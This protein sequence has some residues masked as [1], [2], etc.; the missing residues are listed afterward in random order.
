M[1]TEVSKDLFRICSQSKM[2]DSRHDIHIQSPHCQLLV[3]YNGNM[4]YKLI[5]VYGQTSPQFS[6]ILKR[7]IIRLNLYSK[8]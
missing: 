8:F 3:L 5:S 6:K 7:I 1:V 4:K 2:H